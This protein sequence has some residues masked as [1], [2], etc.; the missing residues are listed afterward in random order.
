MFETDYLP[1]TIH[2]F[3]GLRNLAEKAI[4][5]IPEEKLAVTLSDGENS[6]VILM[7]HLSG[8]ML[9]RWTDFLTTD[10]EKA[11]RNR[12]AEFEVHRDDTPVA[13]RERWNAG[14]HALFHALE[15]LKPEDLSK[16]VTIRGEAHTVFQAIQRQVSHYGYHVGQIVQL[17]R[18]HAGANWKTLS[19]PKGK[20]E[21]ARQ[22]GGAYLK[23]R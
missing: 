14:W 4:E 12:D 9:S 18:H 6:I 3:H 1:G 16:T 20:S 19:I 15:S 21:A 2:V 13:L 10:G 22:A 7:K 17:A 5:Q 11:T 23:P 8:N